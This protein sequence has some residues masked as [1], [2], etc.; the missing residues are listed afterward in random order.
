M[1][2]KPDLQTP[3]QNLDASS[4]RQSRR[5]VLQASGLVVA[6]AAIGVK[7]ALAQSPSAPPFATTV[8]PKF[9]PSDRFVPEIAVAG[10]VAVITGASRG[11]GLATGLALQAAGVTVIGTSRV[12]AGHPNHPFPLLALDITDRASVEAFAIQLSHLLG[13]RTID[14]LINNA[15]RFVLGT[16][17]PIAPSLRSYQESQAAL[18][19]E[20]LYLGH[21]RVT[22]RLLPLMSQT[23]YARLL[24]TVSVAS[25]NVGGTDMAESSGASFA[26]AYY[27]GKRALLAY[28]NNLRAFLKVSGSNIKVST[29]NP[30][31]IHTALL[32]GVNPIVLEPV[33]ASGNS[34][35]PYLQAFL[36]GLRGV[37]ATA[38]PASFVGQTYA[39]LLQMNDPPPNVTVGSPVEPYASQGL[40]A[41]VTQQILGENEQSALPLGAAGAGR[42]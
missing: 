13:G 37:L 23:G 39:Q 25:Y 1:E 24:Y 41:F 35:N 6:G 31:F 42:R 19:M 7:E 22:N 10:K 12:P 14:V 36:D 18:G 9:F 5:R 15:G 16:I 28:A 38:L 30:M 27:A 26:S 4:A 34:Q 32:D 17:V 33:D 21:M 29:I 20:T 40:N 2:K 3:N 8:Q 11:I